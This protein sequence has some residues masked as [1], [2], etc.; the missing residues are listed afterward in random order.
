MEKF[1]YSVEVVL[2]T[3]SIGQVSRCILQE[4]HKAGHEP[5]IFIISNNFDLSAEDEV[6]DDFVKWC[7]SG[8]SKANESYS[9]KNPCLKIWHI[10]RQ[11]III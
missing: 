6:N 11:S 1:D 9:R 8:I 4:L 7:K 2:N 3:L 5:S 10:K